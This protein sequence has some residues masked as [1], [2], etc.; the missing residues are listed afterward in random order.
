M[1]RCKGFVWKILPTDPFIASPADRKRGER[2][3]DRAALGGEAPAGDSSAFLMPLGPF[4]T[5]EKAMAE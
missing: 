3:Q 4:A 5:L 1:K 2:C